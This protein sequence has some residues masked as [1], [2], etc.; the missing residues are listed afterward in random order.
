MKYHSQNSE[1]EI[2]IKYFGHR[3][4]TV[5]D[6]GAN[7]GKFLS[8]SYDLIQRGWSGI[9]L[10]PSSVYSDLLMTHLGNPVVKMFNVGIGDKHEKVTFYESGAH[11]PNGTDKALVSSTDYEETV[12]WRNA[13]VSFTET[14][15]EL[16]DFKTF[17]EGVGKLKFPLISIDTEG[18]DWLILQQIDLRETKT[19]MLIIEWNGHKEL[20]DKFDNY[21]RGFGLK[22]IHQNPENVVYAK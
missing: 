2:A 20:R 9:L 18:H 11:V 1:A 12:R 17:W 14:T 10:E 21:C 22:R 7:E 19:E 5:L 6:I 16:V 8:N 15:V 4:G 3:T 13:G